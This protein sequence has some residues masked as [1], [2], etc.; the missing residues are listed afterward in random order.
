MLVR[1]VFLPFKITLF[2]LCLIYEYEMPH[3]VNGS[4]WINYVY[5]YHI[6]LMTEDSIAQ[7]MMN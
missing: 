5:C 1:Q 2:P 6:L 7:T 3:G 4:E